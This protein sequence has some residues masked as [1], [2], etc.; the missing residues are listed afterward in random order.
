MCNRDIQN[1]IEEMAMGFL[2]ILGGIVA[3]LAVTIIMACCGY[4]SEPAVVAEEPVPQPAL[5]IE[6]DY[7]NDVD[8]PET[9]GDSELPLVKF[10]NACDKLTGWSN[11]SMD[12]QAVRVKL[13]GL[14]LE[15]VGK[16][17]PK[18]PITGGFWHGFFRQCGVQMQI[19]A[20]YHLDE[21]SHDPYISAAQGFL[22]GL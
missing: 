5:Q 13:A 12:E 17:M 11:L 9:S 20:M 8:L 18:N 3:G 14:V 2:A 1:G 7:E 10:A 19:Q 21:L 15:T 22:V 6:I 4:F 16:A